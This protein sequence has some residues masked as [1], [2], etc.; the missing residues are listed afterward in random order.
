MEHQHACDA[1]PEDPGG[2][3]LKEGVV[4][5][6]RRDPG[7][8]LQRLR[9]IEGQVRGLQRMIEEDRYC[10]DILYQLMAVR[11]AL[12]QVGLTLLEDHLR[13]CV[14]GAI[15]TGDGEASIAEMMEVVRRMA[16]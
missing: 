4:S 10:L 6:Y 3:A 2:P 5:R 9:R 7:A 1:H 12:E 16:R 14:T 15:R 8:L 13:G 11:A